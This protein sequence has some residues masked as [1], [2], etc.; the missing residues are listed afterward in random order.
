MG[1][2]ALTVTDLANRQDIQ[3]AEFV[4]TSDVNWKEDRPRDQYADKESVSQDLEVSQKEEAI[5]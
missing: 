2:H 4:T 5:E 1:K 3:L